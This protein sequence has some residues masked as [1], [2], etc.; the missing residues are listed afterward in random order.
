MRLLDENSDFRL[1]YKPPLLHSVCVRGSIDS[2]V[3]AYES[4]FRDDCAKFRSMC[5]KM[6]SD[7]NA[8][9]DDAV[10]QEAGLLYR[11]DYPTSGLVVFAKNPQV[12]IA[13]RGIDI[14]KTYEARCCFANRIPDGLFLKDEYARL[15]KRLANEGHLVFKSYFR[16]YEGNRVRPVLESEVSHYKNKRILPLLRTT[17]IDLPNGIMAPGESMAGC[18]AFSPVR[19]DVR[20]TKGFRHQIRSVLSSLA[21]PI[22]GDVEYGGI[23]GKA[24]GAFSQEAGAGGIGLVCAGL[25]FRFENKSYKLELPDEIRVQSKCF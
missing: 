6:R 4:G 7:G 2:C 12:L 19:F 10:F 14:V 21:F 17:R 5:Q 8:V 11:L 9:V 13:M 1:F 24:A 16:S 23:D 25:E 20:I 15:S 22:V 18:A 3:R